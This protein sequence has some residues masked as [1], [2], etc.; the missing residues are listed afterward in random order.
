MLTQQDMLFV[1]NGRKS[2]T[3]GASN[4]L[5]SIRNK[6]NK[7]DRIEYNGRAYLEQDTRNELPRRTL[8]SIHDK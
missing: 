6:R 1:L 3:V 4:D 5:D 2:C 7:E 8:N